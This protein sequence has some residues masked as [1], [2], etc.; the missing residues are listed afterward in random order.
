M[1]YRDKQGKMYLIYC[2]DHKRNTW[3]IEDYPVTGRMM[4]FDVSDV[5]RF[6]R[7]NGLEEVQK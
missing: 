5:E 3:I 1:K 7:D 2:Y 6:I 4:M